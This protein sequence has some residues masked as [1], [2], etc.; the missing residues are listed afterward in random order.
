[1]THLR[2]LQLIA[3]A[4]LVIVVSDRGDVLRDPIQ[5]CLTLRRFPRLEQF[6]RSV[7][8]NCAN[9]RL[10][11]SEVPPLRNL[12]EQTGPVRHC[13]IHDEAPGVG[14]LLEPD[15]ESVYLRERERLFRVFRFVKVICVG[16]K[17]PAIHI[18]TKS[19]VWILSA[20]L[21]EVLNQYLSLIPASR[22]F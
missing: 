6:L 15:A 22:L 3:I 4:L 7:L 1:M 20:F 12:G 17:S 14:K 19:S 10:L 9:R 21:P 11:V 8:L 18:E 13:V 2:D 16:M 5:G